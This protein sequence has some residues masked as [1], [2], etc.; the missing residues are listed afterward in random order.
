MKT[1]SSKKFASSLAAAK[2]FML[3]ISGIFSFI[4]ADAQ[5]IC[6]CAPQPRVNKECFTKTNGTQGC[7][8]TNC[9]Y[10]IADATAAPDETSLTDV[11]P[12]PVSAST[13]VSFYVGQ[14]KNLS[15]KV[16]DVSGRLITTLADGSFEE[17]DYE[18]TWNAAEVTSGIYFLRMQTEGYSENL[19]LI[20]QK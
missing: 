19:K 2:T 14:T 10:R 15:L 9:R 17:G 1:T 4:L 7:R 3:L 16:Y 11:Y 20:V 6:Y 12:N 13:S 5:C 18:I 8:P